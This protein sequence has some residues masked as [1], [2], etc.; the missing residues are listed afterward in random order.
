MRH[1]YV[2]EG[3]G[4]EAKLTFRLQAPVTVR[5]RLFDS[6]GKP[7]AGA[8]LRVKSIEAEP[9]DD[10]K[11]AT[12]CSAFPAVVSGWIDGKGDRANV[13]API[14]AFI[15]MYRPHE[16]REDTVLFP[17]FQKLVGHAEYDRLGEKFEEREHKMFGEDGFENAVRQ[18]AQLEDALGIG[19]LAQFTP[20]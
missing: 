5:G 18:V 6:E 20:R 2:I 15:R 3:S 17:A 19:D 4:P 16:A 8:T 9:N 12:R 13:E 11:T 14:R 10:L 1:F 7:L